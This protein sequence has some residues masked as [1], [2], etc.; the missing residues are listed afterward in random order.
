[1]RGPR[2]A[3]FSRAGAACEGSAASYIHAG[4][5]IGALLEVNCESDLAAHTDDFKA[6]SPDCLHLILVT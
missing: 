4:G 3:R 1:M 2:H 5:K 6:C